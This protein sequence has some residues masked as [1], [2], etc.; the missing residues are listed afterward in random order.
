MDK[1]KQIEE[2]ANDLKKIKFD[3]KG[4]F[5]P[6]YVGV[7]EDITAKELHDLGYR[8][9]PKNAVVL[10][11]EEYDKLQSL[12]DDYTKGY[13]AGVDE[14]WDNARKETAEKFKKLLKALVADRNCNEDYDWEDVQVDGQIFVECV[15]EICKEITEGKV[16]E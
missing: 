16:K 13:E 10:T 5:V 11:R 1:Q 4:C 2:M 7:Y 12:K 15:D 8:K 3:L 14:G 6:Q 9:I